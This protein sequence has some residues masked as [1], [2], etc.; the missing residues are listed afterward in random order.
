VSEFIKEI[1]L[2]FSR[3]YNRRHNRRGFFWGDRFKNV[4]VEKGQTLINPNVALKIG[5]VQKLWRHPDE[6]NFFKMKMAEFV[7][8]MT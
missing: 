2:G 7:L 8:I 1:K 4:I 3:Y 5:N 6:R